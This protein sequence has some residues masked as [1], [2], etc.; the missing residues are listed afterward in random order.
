M[1]DISEHGG[2]FGGAGGSGVKKIQHITTN[3]GT[4]E[5]TKNIT[6]EAVN[7]DNSYIVSR[8]PNDE[9]GAGRSHF[10]VVFVNAT[11]VKVIRW[12]DGGTPDLSFSVVETTGLKSKQTGIFV[13]TASHLNT[14]TFEPVNTEKSLLLVEATYNFAG[15][16]LR[17]LVYGSFASNSTAL[18]HNITANQSY[19]WQLIEFK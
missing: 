8:S 14:L 7:M 16:T 12:Y 17:H 6:I 13:P 11:T 3:W 2:T 19:Y 10:T 1:I 9:I 18:I 15:S 5:L 4:G